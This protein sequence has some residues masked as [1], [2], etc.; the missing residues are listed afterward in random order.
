MTSAFNPKDVFAKVHVIS[1]IAGCKF[2][3]NIMGYVGRLPVD[4][5]TYYIVAGD[6]KK[7]N[8]PNTYLLK[9]NSFEFIH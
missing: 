6:K 7:S 4:V 9:N 8:F 3:V 2:I 5:R 1:I